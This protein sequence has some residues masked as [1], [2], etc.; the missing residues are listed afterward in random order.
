ML[1][2]N[3]K[4]HTA[5]FAQ[6]VGFTKEALDGLPFSQLAKVWNAIID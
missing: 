1:I 6:L 2:Y 5:P 3:I 4:R